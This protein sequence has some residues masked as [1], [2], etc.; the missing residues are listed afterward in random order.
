MIESIESRGKDK[1]WLIRGL[2]AEVVARALTDTRI[3]VEGKRKDCGH[4]RAVNKPML[5]YTDSTI[6]NR[7]GLNG[8]FAACDG[9]FLRSTQYAEYH[10]VAN[11]LVGNSDDWHWRRR[12]M[13]V[14][15]VDCFRMT[16]NVRWWPP[17]SFSHQA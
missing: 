9:F 17:V 5:I 1:R 7:A 12:V 3:C 4:S 16:S 13:T 6:G 8:S 10:R 11:T 15:L 2:P 14:S